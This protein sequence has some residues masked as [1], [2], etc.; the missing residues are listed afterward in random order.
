MTERDSHRHPIPLS[1]QR[2]RVAPIDSARDSES[3]PQVSEAKKA[4]RPSNLSVTERDTER[5]TRDT[6]RAAGRPDTAATIL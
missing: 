3:I 1:P 2:L 5:V 6:H 4:A